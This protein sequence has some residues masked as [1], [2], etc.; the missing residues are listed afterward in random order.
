MDDPVFINDL[1]DYDI[2]LFPES[3]ERATD[4]NPFYQGRKAIRRLNAIA[5]EYLFSL[6]NSLLHH[7]ETVPDSKKLQ[8]TTE[9]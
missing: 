1:Q 5:R 4:L 9:M 3:H 8:T 7:F 6:T 2:L